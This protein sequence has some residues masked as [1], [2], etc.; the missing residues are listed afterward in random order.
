[1][2]EVEEAG[3]LAELVDEGFFAEDAGFFLPE[4][5]FLGFSSESAETSR[6]AGAKTGGG[7]RC[8]QEAYQ[9]TDG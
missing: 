8:H 2:A 3:F 6:A 1:M 4:E 7:N 5:G 9:R